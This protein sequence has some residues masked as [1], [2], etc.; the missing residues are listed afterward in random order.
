[1][2]KEGGGVRANATVDQGIA[3]G[4]SRNHG[5]NAE[6]GIIPEEYAVEYVVDRVDTTATVW[7][8]LTIG[9]ARCHDH[10]FDPM[11]QKEFYQ[12]FA[13][14]NNVPENGKA[15]K[16]GNSPPMIK[17]PTPRQQEQLA[18]LEHRLT[19]AQSH[20]A[21]LG[22]ELAALQLKWEQSQKPA[23]P[24]Q[25]SVTEGLVAHYELDGSTIDRTG[26]S[27][28]AT[29]QDGAPAYVAGRIGQA[30]GFYRRRFADCGNV[31]DCGFYDKCSCG[32]W[33]YS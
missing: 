7:L 14:F 22:P 9:C 13:Y 23:P 1:M 25:W 32:R 5:G 33:I 2:G 20:F 19:A 11:T 17:A 21:R 10:K 3:A 15:V 18:E 29:F 24:I 31:G 28:A 8:G 27:P 12:T 6:G 26:R 16:Y 30:G 4:F